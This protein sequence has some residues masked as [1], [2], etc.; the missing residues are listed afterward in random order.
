MFV[1]FSKIE[2]NTK[3]FPQKYLNFDML[4][5]FKKNY[6]NYTKPVCTGQLRYLLIQCLQKIAINCTTWKFKFPY[7]RS[8]APDLNAFPTIPLVPLD[9]VPVLEDP[10][11]RRESKGFETEPSLPCEKRRKVHFAKTLKNKQKHINA[12]KAG[13]RIGAFWRFISF[14]SNLLFCAN[15]TMPTYELCLVLRSLPRARL[16]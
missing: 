14:V 1:C 10:P 16:S 5:F 15:Q 12:K 4:A 2:R 7:E 8:F 11:A 3:I 9:E 6:G 13:R